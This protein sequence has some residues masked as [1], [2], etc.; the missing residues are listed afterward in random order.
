[1]HIHRA[2][3]RQ[4]ARMHMYIIII[5]NAQEFLAAF[6]TNVTVSGSRVISSPR[7]MFMVQ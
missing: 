1:M 2:I 3:R 5:V 6:Q 7:V 4:L